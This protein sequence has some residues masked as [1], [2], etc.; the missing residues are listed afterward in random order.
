MTMII[1]ME[2]LLSEKRE[3]AKKNRVRGFQ[4]TSWRTLV[5]KCHLLFVICEKRSSR[6]VVHIKSAG[7]LFSKFLSVPHGLKDK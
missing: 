4:N 7:D 2:R 6:E 1:T 3:E 5:G